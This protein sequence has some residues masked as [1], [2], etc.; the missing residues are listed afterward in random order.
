MWENN[1]EKNEK[2]MDRFE[3]N[4]C[5]KK[6]RKKIEK[7]MCDLSKILW[8]KMRNKFEQKNILW[9]QNFDGKKI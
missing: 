3:E 5:G 9:E 7:K 6:W 8:K 1:W 4:N 2:K